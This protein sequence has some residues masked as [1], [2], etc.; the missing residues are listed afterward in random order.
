VGIVLSGAGAV[1]SVGLGL[2]AS[3]AAIRAGLSRPALLPDAPA[4]L[5]PDSA[6]APPTPVVGHPV[7]GYA[8]G[9]S[10][11]GRWIQLARGALRD[12]LASG[13]VPPPADAAFWGRTAIVVATSP[14]RDEVLLCEPGE[15]E[16]FL[17][18]GFASRV[19]PALSLPVRPEAVHL[20]AAG[21]PACAEAIAT[22]QRL[23]GPAADRV[24]IVAVDSLIDPLLLEAFAGE[25]RLKSAD[26]PVGLAP[27]EAA[28][29][30]LLEDDGWA[31]RRGVPA[32][33]TIAGLAFGDDPASLDSGMPR[34]GR[35]LAG[36]IRAA[37]DGART[38]APYEGDVVVDVNGETWRS[39]EWGAAL[40]R[41]AGRL[42]DPAVR[43]P[44]ASLG[45]T[46]A[47]SG[48]LAIALAIAWGERGAA[49]GPEALVVSSG[50][51]GRVAAAL[52]RRA[53]VR[54]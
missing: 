3:A 50:E 42:G 28:A 16:A 6:I 54:S 17:R 45:D 32:L 7:A 10:L 12:L 36:A 5:D 38:G 29:C 53:R 31:R 51:Q 37:L 13:A 43:F 33:A 18:D 24:L 41:L 15:G 22:A 25:D 44:A 19:A 2:R 23:V 46:G 49:R 1:T 52:I 20:V 11:F 21:H 8:D 40:H 35:A 14:P 47:A 9:F 27:G 48:A 26:Q 4:V 34:L 30:L 39:Q